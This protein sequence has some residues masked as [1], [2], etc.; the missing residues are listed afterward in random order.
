MECGHGGQRLWIYPISIP[1]SIHPYVHPSIHGWQRPCERGAGGGNGTRRGPPAP[2]GGEPAEGAAGAGPVVLEAV[3]L[4]EDRQVRPGQHGRRQLRPA[5]VPARRLPA[6]AAAGG[7]GGADPAEG[8]V[9]GDEAA[10]AAGAEPAAQGAGA[11]GRSG[12]GGDGVGA[13]GVGGGEPLGELVAPVGDEGA[14]REHQAPGW[15][16]GGEARAGEGVDEG[17]DLRR[18]ARDWEVIESRRCGIVIECM[19][20]CARMYEIVRAIVRARR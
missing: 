13:D 18:R 10:R 5:V 16:A 7:R 9:G 15:L 6:A 12:A 11:V 3:A 19:K 8:L 4:V 20:S 1:P 17:D 14:G 2:L